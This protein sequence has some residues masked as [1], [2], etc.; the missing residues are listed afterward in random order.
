MGST[1]LPARPAVEGIASGR[2]PTVFSVGVAA[3]MV[4]TLLT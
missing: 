4:A 3:K 2:G 1:H